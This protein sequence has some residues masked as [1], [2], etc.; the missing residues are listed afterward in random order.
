[1]GLS[2][3]AWKSTIEEDTLRRNVVVV[4]YSPG[5]DECDSLRDSFQEFAQKFASPGNVQA[6]ALNCGKHGSICKKEDQRSLPGATYY[7]PGEVFSKHK[8]GLSYKTLSQWAPRRN[9]VLHGH[10][11]A[12]RVMADF[13]M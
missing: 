9:Q 10:Q 12:C 4:F 5:C 8:G 2:A 7:G 13:C 1:M 11:L 6:A 3:K